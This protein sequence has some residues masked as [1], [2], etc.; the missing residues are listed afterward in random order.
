MQHLSK[1]LLAL[2]LFVAISL[3]QFPDNCEV[4]DTV[5]LEYKDIAGQVHKNCSIIE[6]C[7]HGSGK[8]DSSRIEDIC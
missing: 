2:A 1:V 5:C 8:F 4:G 7:V 6:T 3:A